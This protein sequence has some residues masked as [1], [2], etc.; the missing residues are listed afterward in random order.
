MVKNLDY[1][2]KTHLN[3]NKNMKMV[4]KILKSTHDINNIFNRE[5]NIKGKLHTYILF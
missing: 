4:N 3:D 5:W 2:E 1:R